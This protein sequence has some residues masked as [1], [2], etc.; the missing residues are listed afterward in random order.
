LKTV[1]K[2]KDPWPNVDAAS[3][4]LLYHYGMTEFPYYTVLFSI[5]RALGICAQHII[6]RAMGSPIVRPKSMTS[7]EL[8]TA[9]AA[10]TA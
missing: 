1:Q 4:C 6:H 7:E 10:A 9:I 8:N 3:G 5:S 2:I